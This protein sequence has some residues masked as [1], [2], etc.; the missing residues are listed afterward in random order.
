MIFLSSQTHEEWRTVFL[1]TAAVY[2]LGA[3]LYGLLASGEKQ[4]WK[5]KCTQLIPIAFVR[6]IPIAHIQ[7][8]II[9]MMYF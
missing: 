7:K 3:L 2:A 4:V 8:P 1:I 6:I 9:R 5:Q